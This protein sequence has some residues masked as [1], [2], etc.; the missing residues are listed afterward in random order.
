MAAGAAPAAPIHVGYAGPL[1]HAALLGEADVVVS[2]S[3][4]TMHLAAALGTATVG[5]FAPIRASSPARWGALSARAR[6]VLPPV[7]D[8]ERCIGARCPWW[9]CMDRIGVDSVEGLVRAA[10]ADGERG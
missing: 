6:F 9:D 10:L 3:T 7:P 2:G 1:A 8:C 5:V 4:G